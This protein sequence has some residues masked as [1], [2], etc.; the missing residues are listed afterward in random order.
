[1]KSSPEVALSA[2]VAASMARR[3][4]AWAAPTVLLE[5][6]EFPAKT[7]PKRRKSWHSRLERRRRKG[8]V[9]A[10]GGSD[11]HAVAAA[12]AISSMNAATAVVHTG[13]S[14]QKRPSWWNIFVPD[15]WPR[16]I[17]YRVT[18]NVICRYGNEALS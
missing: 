11:P 10:V 2:A 17:Y 8:V 18:N 4:S 14:K 15:H 5:T 16:Y 6:D 9:M 1:M 3:Q 7:Q 12:A 13:H